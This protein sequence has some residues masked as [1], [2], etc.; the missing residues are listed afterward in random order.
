MTTYQTIDVLCDDDVGLAAGE[1]LHEQKSRFV[2]RLMRGQAKVAIWGLGYLGYHNLVQLVTRGLGVVVTDRSQER[3]ERVSGRVFLEELLRSRYGFVVLDGRHPWTPIQVCQEQA[4][5]GCKD[6]AAHLI[7]VANEKD[8]RPSDEPLLDIMHLL[9]RAGLQR[10]ADPVLVVVE[11]FGVP[12]VIKR[13]VLPVVERVGLRVGRDICVGVAPRLDYGCSPFANRSPVRVVG[14]VTAR[15]RALLEAMYGLLGEEVRVASSPLTAELACTTHRGAQHLLMSYANQL[16][17]AF[18]EIDA[19]ELMDL[20]ASLGEPVLS[21]PGL[22]SSGHFLPVS[23]CHLRDAALAPEMLTLLE[24]TFR[25]DL[26]MV[27]VIADRLMTAGVNRPAILGLATQADIRSHVHS[28]SLKLVGSLRSRG[29]RPVVCDPLYSKTEIVR[30]TECPAVEWPA[31]LRDCDGAVL[32]TGH[33]PFR[34]VDHD[35]LAG[36]LRGLNLILDCSGTWAHKGLRCAGVNYYALGEPGWR[37]DEG[38]R[39]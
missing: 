27:G 1:S 15:C 7:C 35:E 12:D 2:S 8:G 31:G 9:A 4:L 33:N 20:T 37:G 32:V 26:M 38:A 21:R 6:V 29:A 36:H 30:I 25:C 5:A 39:V 3:L 10:R 34:V 16:A 18:G 13:V 28:P 24:E 23:A 22:G 14:G 17:L 11:S 19:R